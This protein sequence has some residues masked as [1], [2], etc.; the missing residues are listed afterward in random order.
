MFLN[1]NNDYLA[2]NYTSTH[3]S[4]NY[5]HAIVHDRTVYPSKCMS[6]GCGIYRISAL[7][8]ES[9]LHIINANDMFSFVFYDLLNAPAGNTT[10]EA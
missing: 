10:V 7:S 9:V 6:S 4:E 3:L 1:N 8:N 2:Y 5:K